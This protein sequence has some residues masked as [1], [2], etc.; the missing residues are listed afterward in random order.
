MRIK[1]LSRF[2]FIAAMLVILC[3]SFTQAGGW[4]KLGEKTVNYKLDHDIINVSLR[5][6]KFRQLRFVVKHGGLNMHKCTVHFENG[7]TQDIDLRHTFTKGSASRIVDLNGNDRFIEKISFW[8]DSKD[9]SNNKAVLS[10][11]GK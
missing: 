1:Q 7:G 4:R 11:F 6:G 5:D 8:Y 10:V 9:F 2:S 3:M